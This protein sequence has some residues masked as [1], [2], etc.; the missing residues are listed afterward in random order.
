MTCRSSAVAK[1]RNA[2]AHRVRHRWVWSPTGVGAA[3]GQAI[4][5]VRFIKDTDCGVVPD[6]L[7]ELSPCD[8]DVLLGLRGYPGVTNR[9][10]KLYACSKFRST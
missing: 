9:K 7:S 1:G 2:S 5:D 10:P 6:A 3:Q 8:F 4:P